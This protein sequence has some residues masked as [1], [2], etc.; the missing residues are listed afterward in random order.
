MA[1]KKIWL[2][3]LTIVL[4]FGLVLTGCPDINKDNNGNG[5][6][7]NGN[8]NGNGGGI[9][10]S[11][12]L[13][14]KNN[15]FL[16]YCTF[17]ERN[18]LLVV[19]PEN[20]MYY[21]G[22]D[23][24]IQGEYDMYFSGKDGSGDTYIVS[25]WMS[26][27]YGLAIWPYNGLLYTFAEHDTNGLPKNE[28]PMPTFLSFYGYSVYHSDICIL[29]KEDSPNEYMWSSIELDNVKA[30]SV[31]TISNTDAGIPETITLPLKFTF[32]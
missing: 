6:N 28:D 27:S 30:Y 8:G 5:Q 12:K 2:G 32:E 19:S 26:S 17:L 4:T 11:A 21:L 15:T 22:W 13:Y 9:V 20:Y 31:E 29:N 25:S 24:K 18:T 14:D 1:N 23:G 7:G 16:G 10:R 3:M